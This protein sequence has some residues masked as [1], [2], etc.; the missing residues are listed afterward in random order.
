MKTISKSYGTFKQK[1]PR[2]RAT[3]RASRYM[4]PYEDEEDLVEKEEELTESFDSDQENKWDFET[5]SPSKHNTL[6]SSKE[7]SFDNTQDYSQYN[8]HNKKSP[9]RHDF[10][11]LDDD[12]EEDSAYSRLTRDRYKM[13]ISGTRT[14]SPSRRERSPQNSRKI[15]HEDDEDIFEDKYLR[16]S[17]RSNSPRRNHYSP[18]QQQLQQAD[19]DRKLSVRARRYLANDEIDDLEDEDIDDIIRLISPIARKLSKAKALSSSTNTYSHSPRSEPLSPLKN[20]HRNKNRGNLYL[21]SPACSPA[22]SIGKRLPV[23]EDATEQSFD[24]NLSDLDQDT[25]TQIRSSSPLSKKKANKKAG[26]EKYLNDDDDY[27]YTL[28]NTKVKATSTDYST[29]DSEDNNPLKYQSAYN[30]EKSLDSKPKYFKQELERNEDLHCLSSDSDGHDTLSSL[31]RSP[32]RPKTSCP[33]KIEPSESTTSSTASSL[34]SSPHSRSTKRTTIFDNL[35]EEIEQ[36]SIQQQQQQNQSP[37]KNFSPSLYDLDEF[38]EEPALFSLS[39][40]N[41]LAAK[42]KQHS[43]AKQVNNKHKDELSRSLPTPSDKFKPAPNISSSTMSLLRKLS[44]RQ[45]TFSLS[46][47]STMRGDSN[48]NLEDQSTTRTATAEAET[49]SSSPTNNTVFDVSKYDM[50]D[51]LNNLSSFLRGRNS[52]RISNKNRETGGATR[53][54]NSVSPSR[55]DAVDEDNEASNSTIIRS[56]AEPEPEPAVPKNKTL[57]R[58]MSLSYEKSIRKTIPPS[59]STISPK[60]LP[61]SHMGSEQSG[62]RFSSPSKQNDISGG[63]GIKGKRLGTDSAARGGR[64]SLPHSGSAASARSRSSSPVRDLINKHNQLFNNGTNKKEDQEEKSSRPRALNSNSNNRFPSPKAIS[65]LASKFENVN[66]NDNEEL[67]S[68]ETDSRRSPSPT[69]K[70]TFSSPLMRQR[71]QELEELKNH[72]SHGSPSTQSQSPL[73]SQSQS[74]Q[75]PQSP[76]RSRSR[77]GTINKLSNRYA[78]MP[79]AEEAISAGLAAKAPSMKRAVSTIGSQK[80]SRSP[81]KYIPIP[82]SVSA[83]SAAMA[84][85]APSLNTQVTNTVGERDFTLKE[86][87][88]FIK[89]SVGFSPKAGTGSRIESTATS[90][91]DLD[92]EREID[93]KS[94]NKLK[95][96]VTENHWLGSA[97]QRSPTKNKQEVLNLIHEKPKFYQSIENQR[98]LHEEMLAEEDEEENVDEKKKKQKQEEMVDLK[99]IQLRRTAKPES[100]LKK[101]RIFDEIPDFVKMRN[102]KQQQQQQRQSDNNSNPSSPSRKPKEETFDFKKNLNSSTS[103]TRKNRFSS[104]SPSSSPSQLA[105]GAKDAANMPTDSLEIINRIRAKSPERLT[106]IEKQARDAANRFKEVPEDSEQIINKIRSRSPDKISQFERNKMNTFKEMP[107]DASEIIN[108]IRSKSPQRI[109]EFE[110][111]RKSKFDNVPE[112]AMEI[113]NRI[114]KAKN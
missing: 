28:K 31:R 71:A 42:L 67:R 113:I 75:T 36:E 23:I 62:S 90:A 2:S 50:K 22:R 74:P 107:D 101:D 80:Q 61:V 110:K 54:S 34:S 103:E 1:S 32:M 14:P 60:S 100:P 4:P 27:D 55:L 56:S 109:S 24:S 6:K 30:Y 33:A 111:A 45:S 17:T 9:T 21:F 108:K 57:E 49:A 29:D 47:T 76:L 46:P 20:K 43:D 35:E 88:K 10:G 3:K 65:S 87:S 86:N 64:D 25:Y 66:N 58:L 82:D 13:S 41:S 96:K 19:F 70:T 16:H 99:S 40:P 69:G 8:H 81:N 11:D 102:K 95:I 72:T 78:P 92:I 7:F 68:N 91:P 84:A 5:T 26:W 94:D 104:P 106:Q 105:S 97:I 51:D 77:F 12:D 85:K 93:L 59:S 98:K 63:E 37:Q 39:Q 44:E 112:D 52:V 18:K 79:R 83:I 38:E 114:R 15:K 73:Q 89:P 53:N 48:Y